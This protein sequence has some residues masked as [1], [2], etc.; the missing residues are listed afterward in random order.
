MMCMY[1]RQIYDK[2]DK[3]L[4]FQI[5]VPVS[6]FFTATQI[7]QTV[8]NPSNLITSFSQFYPKNKAGIYIILS[9][10]TGKSIKVFSFF[11]AVVSFP[12]WVAS[13]L[14][15]VLV[16]CLLYRLF[17]L[18][19]QASSFCTVNLIGYLQK[20]DANVWGR[21]VEGMGSPEVI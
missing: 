20:S 8:P 1:W 12:M 15:T 10:K 6:Q 21:W 13:S 16:S 7:L 2:I 11:L 17:D 19:I 18:L 4:I 9:K 5:K 3:Y 14:L